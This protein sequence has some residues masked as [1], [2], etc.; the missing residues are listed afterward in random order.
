MSSFDLS[1]LYIDFSL[2]EKD[3]PILDKFPELSA[4]SEFRNAIHDNEIKIAILTGDNESPFTMIK[5]RET[6][7]TS[8]FDFLKIPRDTTP[9]KDFYKEVF[10]YRHTRVMDCWIRYIQIIHDTDFT[11]WLMMQETYNFLLFQSKIPRKADENEDKYLDRRLKIQTN[12]KKIGADLKALEIKLYP[13]SKAAREASLKE[14]I[15]ISL[16]AEKYAEDSTYI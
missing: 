3:Q 15:K 8:I 10:A 7:L 1:K 5:D 12:I 9:Q 11:D 4:F 2:C 14:N 13:D 6:M 16:Y